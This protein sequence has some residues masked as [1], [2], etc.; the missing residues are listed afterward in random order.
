MT[1]NVYISEFY[2][3]KQVNLRKL[4]TV[5]LLKLMYWNRNQTFITEPHRPF[6][7]QCVFFFPYW[8][9]LFQAKFSQMEDDNRNMSSRV[10]SM[11]ASFTTDI[12]QLRQEVTAAQQAVRAEPQAVR[13]EPQV[14]H[15]EPP[16]PPGLPELPP[17]TAG[18][19]IDLPPPVN[20]QPQ[21]KRPRD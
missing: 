13:A 14:V 12:Q 11:A 20:T 7:L 6:I 17:L 3:S 15:A 2:W 8:L 18:A 21:V 5:K 1:V 10:G 16:R 4:K 19:A 9:F